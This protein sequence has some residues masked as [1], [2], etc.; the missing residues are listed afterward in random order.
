MTKPKHIL[1]H[2]DCYFFV[3]ITGPSSSGKSTVSKVLQYLFNQLSQHKDGHTNGTNNM[4][5]SSISS[6]IIYEDDFYKS[7]A[8]MPFNVEQH[9]L[10]YDCPDSLHM[11]R[12]INE[13]RFIKKHNKLSDQ[14]LELGLDSDQDHSFDPKLIPQNELDQLSLKLSNFW[15]DFVNS[16]SNVSSKTKISLKIVIIDGFLLFHDDAILDLLDL[17][18]FFRLPYDQL[19]SR[20]L[21]RNGYI[22]SDGLWIDPPNYFDDLVWPSYIKYHK[23]LFENDDMERGELSV[24]YKD[25]IQ[26]LDLN[27]HQS[28]YGIM[29]NCLNLIFNSLNTYIPEV[30]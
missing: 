25:S 11:D 26:L 15:L 3:G 29:S 30:H 7:D 18:L 8:E 22:T 16:K 27:S 24:N 14:L 2:D 12:F 4:H 13:L 21:N 1:A 10:D 6:V 9:Q 17:K 19:K 20:R 5:S 28:L 23:H